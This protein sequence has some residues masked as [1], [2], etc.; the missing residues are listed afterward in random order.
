MASA[1]R[2]A[3]R[4]AT[5]RAA[6]ARRR[7]SS[8]TILAGGAALLLLL[9]LIVIMQA[10]NAYST[11]Y[12]QFRSVAED[13]T[14]KVSAAEAALG[15]VFDI[16]THAASFVATAPDNQNH[17]KALDTI[18]AAYQRFREQMFTVR[19]T[20][21]TDEE[22]QIYDQIDYF[23]FDQFWQHIG[24]LLTAQQNGDKPT[25]ISQYIIADNYL[26][27]QIARYLL[28]LEALNFKTMQDTEQ[29]AGKIITTQMIFVG[30]LVILLAIGL[31]ALSFWLRGKVRR[32][33]TPGLDLAMIFGW[34]LAVLMLVELARAPGQLSHMVDDA[35]YSVSASSRVLAIASEANSAQSGSVIDPSHAQ[36]WQSSFDADKNSLELRLCGSP[37]CTATPFT[38]GD[39][40][41]S[42]GVLSAAKQ[43]TQ[44]NSDAIN[45]IQPLIAKVAFTGEAS[46]LETAR[47]AL[48]DYLKIDNQVRD[49]IKTNDP[50][51]LDD[52]T[53]L[54]TG[55]LAGQSG[56]AFTRFS[57]AM[58]KERTINRNVFDDIWNTQKAALPL[59]RLLFGLIGFAL[60]AILLVVG[61][62]HRFREL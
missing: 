1:T 25:A 53:R 30:V 51:K 22:Q 5:S 19:S 55:S 36:F 58:N 17:W 62:Y 35:Y 40:Q 39:D 9:T 48:G 61:V 46:T 21:Q 24:N 33:I 47:V 14:A 13:S 15:A 54:S 8:R 52:A 49:L 4:T 60:V 12:E 23:A 32:V 38:A 2:S 11:T 56:E 18:H 3:P 43:I 44:A 37:G 7:L 31:T 16:D 6:P 28:Q 20:L 45:G 57:D 34:V 42:P 27:N 29:N 26:Q 59:H 50:N 10:L 41:V